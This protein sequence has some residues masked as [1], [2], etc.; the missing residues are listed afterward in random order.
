MIDEEEVL[1][2]FNKLLETKIEEYIKKFGKLPSTESLPNIF[3][4]ENVWDSEIRYHRMMMV[5]KQ[6]FFS[7]LSNGE[8]IEKY[9]KDIRYLWDNI[10]HD[11]MT[12]AIK[13]LQLIIMSEDYKNAKATQRSIKLQNFWEEFEKGEKEYYKLNPE[14]DF[15]TLEQR[16][17]N[18]HIKLYKNWLKRF[19]PEQ[20]KEQIEKIVKQYDSMDKT[21][22]YYDHHTGKI[23]CYNTISTYNSMLYNVNLLRSA[24]NRTAYDSRLL[25][26][27]LWYL[28]AHRYACPGCAYYQG[29]VYA[30][31]GASYMELLSIEPYRHPYVLYVD[32]VL[33][34]KANMGVTI[35]HPN[36]KH[37]WS[38]FWSDSQVQTDKYNSEMW[39]EKYKTQ[40]KIQSLTLQKSKL[41]TDR[42]I[43]NDLGREDLVDKTTSK[44]K[45]LREKIKELE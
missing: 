29:Y 21:I 37:S 14:R 5:T 40:Q 18:R 30:E 7:Y 32:D 27:R 20:I 26:N 43:Y 34:D 8:S 24:W 23:K 41:L 15:R 39:E 6:K 17:V 12:K 22:P 3:I 25:G 10:D 44:I 19:T 45:T 36:C 4:Q 33:N 16:Y 13:E 2:E 9:E 35:G 11:Y 28:P 31:R 1:K 42:R 38:L